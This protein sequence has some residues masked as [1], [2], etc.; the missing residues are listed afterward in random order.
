MLCS[1]IAIANYLSVCFF[2]TF[3][4]SEKVLTCRLYQQKENTIKSSL[5]VGKSPKDL[6]AHPLDTKNNV[7]RSRLGKAAWSEVYE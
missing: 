7:G 4:V 3:H 6:F 2:Q 5:E 1:C